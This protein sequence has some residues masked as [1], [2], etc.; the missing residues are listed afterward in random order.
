MEDFKDE[1]SIMEMR[2]QKTDNLLELINLDNELQEINRRC[3]YEPIKDKKI[4]RDEINRLRLEITNKKR[5]RSDKNKEDDT[6]QDESTDLLKNSLRQLKETEAIASDT[7]VRLEGQNIQIQGQREK[8]GDI[9]GN[10]NHSNKLLNKM[11]NSWG[12]F[13]RGIFK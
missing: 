8:V 2:I 5:K 3:N 13:W 4:I 12:N 7:L 1:L 6:S 11:S 9:N 10:L